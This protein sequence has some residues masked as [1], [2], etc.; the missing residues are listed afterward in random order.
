MKPSRVATNA[1]LWLLPLLLALGS[2]SAV[3]AYCRTTTCSTCMRDPETGCSDGGVPLAWANPCVSFSMEESAASGVEL[4]T[5][6]ALMEEAFTSWASVRCPPNAL[7]PS[8]HVSHAFGT[9]SC[10][11][12]EY[13][14][15]GG[16]ANVVMFREDSWPH[17]ASAN[18]LAATRV[19]FDPES[20]EI[21][22]VDMEINALVPLSIDSESAA[23]QRSLRRVQKGIVPGSHDLRSIMLHEA[24]HFLGLDHSS[25]PEAVMRPELR[26]LEQV[27]TL[28]PDDVA[29]ICEVYPPERAAPACDPTP[30]GGFSPQCARPEPVHSTCSLQPSRHSGTSRACLGLVT[31]TLMLLWRR[32]RR[33]RRRVAPWPS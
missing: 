17:G 5:A 13:N 27:T 28:S 29:A 15:V 7:P 33:S 21:L 14:V 22:D 1:L 11:E 24:G 10:A 18:A 2:A 8:I 16:N 20:G 6:R 26:E 25:D 23:E 3:S 19:K 31:G 4:E 30:R 32:S 12:P 9:V